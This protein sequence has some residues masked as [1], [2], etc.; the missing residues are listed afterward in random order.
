MPD[1]NT[2]NPITGI[3]WQRYRE[4]L[5]LITIFSKGI[6]TRGYSGAVSCHVVKLQ[7]QFKKVHEEVEVEC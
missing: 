5:S 1:Y 7:E 2:D 4:Y 3:S 6:A